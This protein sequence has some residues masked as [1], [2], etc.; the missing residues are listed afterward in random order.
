M[1][2]SRIGQ[3]AIGKSGL[4]VARLGRHEP[5]APWR[6][7]RRRRDSG[8]CSIHPRTTFVRPA[9]HPRFHRTLR[10]GPEHSAACPS[11]PRSNLTERTRNGGEQYDVPVASAPMIHERGADARFPPPHV[12][13]ALRG[14]SPTPRSCSPPWLLSLPVVAALRGCRCCPKAAMEDRSYG[15]EGVSSAS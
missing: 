4:L 11:S 8:W 1:R 10:W 2:K 7:V 15:L 9:P 6:N 14:C 13:A 5:P 12:V 3:S